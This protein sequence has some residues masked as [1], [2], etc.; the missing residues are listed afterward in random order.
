MGSLRTL[1]GADPGGMFITPGGTSSGG[2]WP[3]SWRLPG[4][5]DLRLRDR[6][7]ASAAM[8]ATPVAGRRGGCRASSFW[9]R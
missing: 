7:K 8:V 9:F 5:P 1:E 6:A 2:G 4:D 3:G